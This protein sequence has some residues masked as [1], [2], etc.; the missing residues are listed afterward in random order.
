MAHPMKKDAVEGHNSKMRRMTD[1]YGLASGDKNNIIAEAEIG[2]REGPESGHGFGSSAV[3]G[4]AP[5]QR[6]DRPAR[7]RGGHVKHKKGGTHVNVI[8][9]PQSGGPPGVGAAPPMLPHPPMPGPPMPPPGAGGPPG[10]G[11]PPK[12]PMGGPPPALMGA[13]GAPGGIPPGL[14]APHASGGRV[15]R[16]LDDEGLK[17][18]DKPEKY[19]LRERANGGRVE[20]IKGQTAGALSGPGRLEKIE[21][22]KKSKNRVH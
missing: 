4:K 22:Q 14:F 17:R 19:G 2:K 9:A 13:P 12:P 16:T 5:I 20:Q 18:S 10:A 7:A 3:E 11:M 8:V 6:A 1:G 21:M 15:Q